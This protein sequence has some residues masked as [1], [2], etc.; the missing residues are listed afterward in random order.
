MSKKITLS[1]AVVLLSFTLIA[2]NKKDAQ[3]DALSKESQSKGEEV[4]SVEIK[5][6]DTK[7]EIKEGESKLA[8]LMEK[9]EKIRCEYK[10]SDGAEEMTSIIYIDGEKFRTEVDMNGL[11]AVGVFDGET[12]YN[13]SRGE[14]NQ[15]SQ[16]SRRC[17]EEM[18]AKGNEEVDDKM[19]DMPFESTDEIITQEAD[20]K[21]TCAKTEKIDF[22][23]PKDIKFIDTCAMLEQM[24]GQ[25]ENME[26]MQKQM[27]EMSK[28]MGM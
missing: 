28:N 13:W 4:V 21:M 20:L 25:V 7:V 26:E 19:K 8:S 9:G 11:E 2:C 23:I 17:M 16:M 12:Y 24:E 14:V 1:F 22:T 18:E 27:E 5:D 6:G 3:K 10:M 15:G